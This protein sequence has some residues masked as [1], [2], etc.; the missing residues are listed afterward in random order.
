M[1]TLFGHTSEDTALVVDD[2]PYGRLRTQI[3]Y[4]IETVAKRGD[5]FVSQTLNPKTGRWNKPKKS[6]YMPV[7]VM[8]RAEDV[9]E[10]KGIVKTRYA[11]LREWADQEQFDSFL[12]LAG[13]N[14]N[15]EQKKQVARVTALNKVFSKV[16]WTVR[17][18]EQTQEE[19]QEQERITG[20]INRAV[21]VEYVTALKSL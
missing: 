19:Q 16:T 15:D 12:A 8:T 6:T 1:E 13:D 10:G 17:E 18:G 21:A 2:Y 14:L 20:T 4:W 11:G 9:A 5:R 7:M 3:R